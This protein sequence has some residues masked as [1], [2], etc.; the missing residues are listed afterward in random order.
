MVNVDD[1][2]EIVQ[3][4]NS[5]VFGR[6]GAAI[7]QLAR[8]RFIQRINQQGR[9]AAARHARH[10]GEGAERDFRRHILQIIAARAF[11][12]NRPVFRTGAALLGH[13][14]FQFTGEIF[15]GQAFGVGNDFCRGALSDDVA[16]MNTG[17]RADID[18][19][20]GGHNGF[21]V[22]LD[23]NHRIAEVAQPN[24]GL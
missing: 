3:P 6:C 7:I 20:V 4:F 15:T 19:V 1:F 10:A 2:V 21:F 11:D 18:N 8:Q 23:D 12:H 22:M 14:H 9:F 13:R 5:V 24:E 16:A 17:A